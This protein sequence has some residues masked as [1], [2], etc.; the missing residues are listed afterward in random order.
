[1][2]KIFFREKPKKEKLSP[3]KSSFLFNQQKEKIMEFY[4][5]VKNRIEKK[6]HINKW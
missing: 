4:E 3:Y 6:I 2:I 1:M 5:V